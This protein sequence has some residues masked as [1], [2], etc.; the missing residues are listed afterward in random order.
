MKQLSG[1]YFQYL[2]GCISSPDCYQDVEV[3]I[4]CA[5][6]N[7]F[8]AGISFLPHRNFISHAFLVAQLRVSPPAC[9]P[10]ICCFT[11]H[12]SFEITSMAPHWHFFSTA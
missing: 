2:G 12:F 3:S 6:N 4:A 7:V 9:C 1:L 5:Y 10:S 8:A 11:N